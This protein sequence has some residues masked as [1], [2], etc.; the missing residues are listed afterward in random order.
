MKM[1]KKLF[2]IGFTVLLVSCGYR[3]D[4]Y[5]PKKTKVTSD[6]SPVLTAESNTSFIFE[7]SNTSK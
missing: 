1:M 7:S 2:V 4:L 3:G 5:L 6:G